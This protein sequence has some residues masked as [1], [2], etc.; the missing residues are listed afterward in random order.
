M[1]VGIF[2][3]IGVAYC[4]TDLFDDDEEEEEE[5]VAL[6]AGMEPESPEE[7]AKSKKLFQNSPKNVRLFLG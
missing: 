6:K 1:L 7:K 3:I 2:V 4:T 5:E